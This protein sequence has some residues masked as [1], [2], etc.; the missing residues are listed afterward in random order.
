MKQSRVG[1]KH[2]TKEGY[3]IEIIEYFSSFNSTIQFEDNTIL[4]N[5]QYG[6]IITG[7]IK[8]P[9]HN[10]VVGV[11][12]IGIG[13]YTRKNHIK[14]YRLWKGV[15]E[16]CYSEK[17]IK[18][19]PSYKDVTV[20]KKWHNFQNF[21]Q[22]FEENYVEGFELDKDILVKGNKIYSPETCCFVPREINTLFMKNNNR[23][24]KL[25]VGVCKLGNRFKSA[26]CI[27]GEQIHLGYFTTP[28]EAFEVY[29]NAKEDW[30]KKLADKWRDLIKKCLYQK[31][32]NYQV[33][34]TD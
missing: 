24:G 21:A 34:I 12:F 6:N 1:E 11:G 16:R 7:L 19:F 30:I 29:K 32:Y 17:H 10:S 22:W 13:K 3:K 15:L 14:I 28:E 9:Y 20:C 18:K 33:E 25:P 23:R 8:N 31:M 5:I 4:K 27:N 2:I 26:L